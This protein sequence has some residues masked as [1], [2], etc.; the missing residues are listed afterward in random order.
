MHEVLRLA[1]RVA[2]TDAPVLIFGETGVGKE[3][4]ARAIHERSQRAEGPIVKVNCGAIPPELIDSELFGHERGSFTGAFSSRLGWFERADG[5][6]L[7]LDEIGE[8]PP[9]VQVRLLRV[10]QDGTFERVGGGSA[11]R[12][13]VRV[14]AATHRDLSQLVASGHFRQDLWYR[15]NVFPLYI[16]PLRERIADLPLLARHFATRAAARFGH[17][18][19][20]PTHEDIAL[21]AA[22]GWPGNVRELA[23]VIERAAIL[24]HGEVLQVE[25]AL[26][27]G[28]NRRQSASVATAPHQPVEPS[29]I[30]VRPLEAVVVEHIERALLR[31]GGRI[32]GSAGAAAL[33]GV[34][35]HTLR[36]RMR[37]LGINWAH[38]R[39]PSDGR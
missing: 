18:P 27:I 25:A 23:A 17:A 21:L 32:E 10:L 20:M 24:G 11:R 36:A 5:G 29:S 37:K 22:Y 4:A 14:I 16:P 15:I 8:L 34:N 2:R 12:T 33:L 38:F 31:T 1:H 35:P 9:A 6:T 28:A 7:F 19:L 3:V 13:D 39:V 26:P 30:E